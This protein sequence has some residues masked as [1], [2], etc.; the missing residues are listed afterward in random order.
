MG[1]KQNQKNQHEE[2]EELD[3]PSI[4]KYNHITG[5]YKDYIIK[6]LRRADKAPRTQKAFQKL[7]DTV[8]KQ[9]DDGENKQKD[10]ELLHKLI[11]QLE[12]FSDAK[13]SRKVADFNNYENKFIFVP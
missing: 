1:N 5:D 8:K 4:D 10:T 3:Q 2:E 6:I 12:A 13:D 11:I 9:K 7:I